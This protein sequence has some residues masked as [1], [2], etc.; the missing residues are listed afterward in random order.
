MTQQRVYHNQ[1]CRALKI[2]SQ[3]LKHGDYIIK[4]NVRPKF[5]IC[6]EC[7][8]E[9]IK[10]NGFR[11][12][13]FI[14]VPEG[15]R[16]VIL[17]C[18]IPR[19]I[20]NDCGANRQIVI[21]FADQYMSYTRKSAKFFVQEINHSSIKSVSDR[22]NINYSLL[23]N[24]YYNYLDKKYSK[25]DISNLKLLAIDEIAIGKNHKYAT[26]VMNY[27]TEQVI[28]VNEGKGADSLVPFWKMIGPRRAKNIKAVAMDMS[29]AFISAVTENLPNT[30]VIFDHFHVVKLLNKYLDDLR[31]MV[32]SQATEEEK[33]VLRGIK[34]ILLKR[35]DTLTDERN[36]KTRLQNA[37]A[38][39]KPLF[40]GYYMKE[41]VSQIW[42]QESKNNAA[43]ILQ[44]WVNTGFA[45][46]NPI[47]T[48]MANSILKFSSGILN[49]YDFPIT[50][51]TL[52]GLNNKIKKIN[53]QSF[54]IKSF[55]YYRLRI[56][57]IH[58][59]DII[60]TGC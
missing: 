57:G 2:E 32:F 50:T 43:I 20:C 14:G 59:T 24:M 18:N 37:V 53:R 21:P 47:I 29:P 56:L 23:Y 48:K 27:E 33:K 31:K 11:T 38:I 55:N 44:N 30:M 10:Y 35:G 58:D 9:N 16:K 12:R 7:K 52:E 34:W 46:D 49:W 28:F 1:G 26:L 41:D 60:L 40:I 39:N 13:E 15:Y 4:C 3:A 19:V 54:G 42:E 8:S 45:S 5:V 36:E 22:F 6:P 17:S 51:A 25:P